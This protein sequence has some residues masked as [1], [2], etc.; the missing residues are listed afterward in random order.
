M[1]RLSAPA[2]KFTESE[3]RHLRTIRGL[4]RES[5]SARPSLQGGGQGCFIAQQEVQQRHPVGIRTLHLEQGINF[6]DEQVEC[7]PRVLDGIVPRIRQQL[8]ALDEPV[9]RVGWER[10][11]RKFERVEDRQIEACQP[12]VLAPQL[13][14]VV[15]PKVVPDEQPGA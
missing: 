7:Q 3:S 1:L 9:I 15:A 6:L 5:P 13:R 4:T 10:D 12:G 14:H 2:P 11:R 8:V